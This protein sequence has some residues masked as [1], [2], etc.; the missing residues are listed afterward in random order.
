MGAL[1]QPLLTPGPDLPALARPEREV[2]L[3]VDT[4]AGA[5]RLLAA[6]RSYPSQVQGATIPVLDATAMR[7]ARALARLRPSQAAVGWYALSNA[8]AAPI[9]PTVGLSLVRGDVRDLA[10]ALGGAA[11]VTDVRREAQASA[12]E[13][14]RALVTPPS[15]GRITA[16]IGSLALGLLLGLITTI[17][18]RWHWAHVPFGLLL[19]LATLTVGALTARALAKGA[20]LLGFAVGAVVAVQAMA[21]VGVGG[22]VLVPGD[23]LGMVWLLGSVLAVGL[24]AFLPDRWVGR[25]A[26]TSAAAPTPSSAPAGDG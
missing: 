8:V 25:G 4:S 20:G 16:V 3:E 18:H 14:S 2:D 17:V 13:A 9:L 10:T 26:K 15:P 7:P 23:T 19:A 12:A 11:G 24:A 6:L 1:A 22:D 21:F 5:R